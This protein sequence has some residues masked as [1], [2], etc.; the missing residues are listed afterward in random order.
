MVLEEHDE[1]RSAPHSTAAPAFDIRRTGTM[2]VSG[3]VLIVCGVVTSLVEPEERLLVLGV[4]QTIAAIIVAAGV[5]RHASLVTRSLPRV[6]LIVVGAAVFVLTVAAN[7]LAVTMMLVSFGTGLVHPSVAMPILW[8]LI[9]VLGGVV[10]V[11]AVIA[12][13]DLG[14]GGR[15]PAPW[16]WLALPV[17]I[18]GIVGETIK[19]E[20]MATA[21]MAWMPPRN[22][23]YD[24]ITEL[25]AIG[26]LTS[27]AVVVVTSALLGAVFWRR[28]ARSG[29]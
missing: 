19:A 23:L 14:R 25:Q 27:G 28:G 9:A 21:A 29:R 15:I 13:V 12:G 26:A 22:E 4:G 17:M 2:L 16:G 10:A 1:T 7:T 18:A 8:G 3:V 24:T 5:G 6:S 11:C 20:I